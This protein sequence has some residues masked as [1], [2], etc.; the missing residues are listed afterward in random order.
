MRKFIAL[1]A[2]ILATLPTAAQASWLSR[3]TGVHINANGRGPVIRIEPPQPQAIPEMLRNLPQ[4]AA[5]F[6]LSP[7]GTALAAAIRHARGQARSSAAAMPPQVRQALAPF[8]PP[9]ILDKVRW[10]TRNDLGFTL[11][12]LVLSLSDASAIT[13]DDVIVFDHGFNPNATDLNALELWA[14]EVTHVVQYQNMGVESFAFVYSYNPR[15]L[16]GQA[17]SNASQVRQRIAQNTPA[18]GYYAV[19]AYASSAQIGSQQIGQQQLQQGA[20]QIV[21][22][23]NCVRWQTNQVG[24]LVQN[25]C[26]VPIGILG[27]TQINPWNGAPFGM[28]CMM[29]CGIAPGEVKQFTSPQPGLWVNIGF[30]F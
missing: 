23:A 11:D 22:P 24:A 17:E 5:Q 13:L 16:E 8:F 28:P 6:L 1:G 9:G 19:D 15:S 18:N 25:I 29:N 12:N 30:R 20:T 26:I 7:H 27:W 4:D 2:I 10:K 14:H 3:I 21:P